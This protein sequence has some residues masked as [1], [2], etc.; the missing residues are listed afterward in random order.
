MSK[1]W[2]KGYGIDD[3]GRRTIVITENV[4]KKTWADRLV[5]IVTHCTGVLVAI[6]AVLCVI[7]M[8]V[9]NASADIA[10]FIGDHRWILVVALAVAVLFFVGKVSERMRS[11][12]NHED[13]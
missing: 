4:P 9:E 10:G 13:C 6:C 5:E 11:E 7:I 8:M 2:Q 3:E 12:G 1:K